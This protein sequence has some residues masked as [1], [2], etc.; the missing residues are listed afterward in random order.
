MNALFAI[1]I[2]EVLYEK[3]YREYNFYLVSYFD[4]HLVYGVVL[5]SLFD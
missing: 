2:D 5:V 1:Q 3:M 4:L